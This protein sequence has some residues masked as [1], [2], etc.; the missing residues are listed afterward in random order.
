MSEMAPATPV[1]VQSL[2]TCSGVA[3]SERFV[4]IE[5]TEDEVRKIAGAGYTE[6]L[7]GGATAVRALNMFIS[8]TIAW[9]G[10]PHRT[11]HDHLVAMGRLKCDA[12]IEAEGAHDRRSHA[13]GASPRLFH[14]ALHYRRSICRWI[15]KLIAAQGKTYIEQSSTSGTKTS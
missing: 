3:G 9:A 6:F 14:L 12:V 2:P 7:S 5:L 1:R 13:L 11:S 15:G 10:L 8:S 4:G